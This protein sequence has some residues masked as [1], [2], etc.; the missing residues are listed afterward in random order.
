MTRT[1]YYELE[2][3]VVNA[4]LKSSQE[5][6]WMDFNGNPDEIVCKN[7]QLV[8]ERMTTEQWKVQQNNDEIIKEV[9]E[10]LKVGPDSCTFSLEQ[11][12]QMFRYR[13]KLI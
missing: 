4:L 13:S 7:F 9:M 1:G 8:T 2:G 3:P 6:D 10:A 11:A 12:K 5:I